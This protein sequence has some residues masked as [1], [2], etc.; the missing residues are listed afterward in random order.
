MGRRQGVRPSSKSSIEIDFYYKGVR[1]K[2]RI[3]KEPTPRNL[4]WAERFK[5]S[6]ELAIAEGSFNYITHF[7]GSKKAQLFAHQ[8]GDILL[9]NIYL[10]NWL[11]SVK[12][13]L[14][15]STWDGYRKMIRNQLIP[16][17]GH[18]TVSGFKRIH[19]KE[20]ATT[21]DISAK[22]MGNV[23]SPM[24]VALDDAVEDEII[25]INPLAGWKIKRQ[26]RGSP[27]KVNKIDPFS[28]DEQQAI[29]NILTG[30]NKNMVKFWL[31]TGLRP[32]ELIALDWPDIDLINKRACI[33]KALTQAAS[34]FEDTKTSAGER[35]VDL[36]EYAITALKA[37]KSHTYLKGEEIFQ[38]PRTSERWTGDQPIRK[39][40]WEPALKRA[41]VRY[42]Y[43]YQ[44]RHTRISTALMAGESPMWVAE[45]AGHK[46][47]RFTADTYARYIPNNNTSA[48][49]KSAAA[50]S[51][52]GQHGSASD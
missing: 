44:C 26:K 25:E 50:W 22:T 42:R 10:E 51:A 38:N 18:L 49:E 16:A 28:Y 37:Q 15:S 27:R 4:A 43:P 46:S 24:R 33:N 1:C 5:A 31:R 39:T 34:E 30:Q 45:Q 14:K 35:F 6:I 2:E 52:S 20:W 47:W 32:S 21:K 23:M 3:K 19:A 7:P 41:G 17:F 29:I 12:P 11:Q 48:G 13:Y 8:P 9:L 40:M 36:D